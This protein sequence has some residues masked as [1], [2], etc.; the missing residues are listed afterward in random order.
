[1]ALLRVAPQRHDVVPSGVGPR[2]SI[3]ITIVVTP[4]IDVLAAQLLL[5]LL[6]EFPSDT[7]RSLRHKPPSHGFRVIVG[8]P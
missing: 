5:F 2:L 1:M 3:G 8:G 4:F 6:E 7:S